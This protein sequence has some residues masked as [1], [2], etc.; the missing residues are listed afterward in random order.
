M[1]T[2]FPNRRAGIPLVPKLGLGT[3]VWEALL[4]VPGA[5][6]IRIGQAREAELPDVRSQAELEGVSQL[7]RRKS[8][9]SVERRI[10]TYE[11]ILPEPRSPQLL[12]FSG[13]CGGLNCETPS[14]RAWE[15]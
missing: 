3:Q 8:L 4:P 2:D 9:F 7:N 10:R 15:R 11:K 5:A 13:T 1:P 12:V 14:S 6:K